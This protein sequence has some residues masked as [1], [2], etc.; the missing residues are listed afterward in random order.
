MVE[1]T[2]EVQVLTILIVCKA[3]LC[4]TFYHRERHLSACPSLEKTKI[5]YAILTRLSM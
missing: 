4:F 5:D 1:R 3:Q 2:G